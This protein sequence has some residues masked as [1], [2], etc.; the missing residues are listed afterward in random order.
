MYVPLIP[1]NGHSQERT[2][3]RTP[4]EHGRGWLITV[5]IWLLRT[6][7]CSRSTLAAAPGVGETKPVSPTRANAHGRSAVIKGRVPPECSIP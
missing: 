4:R 7:R 6:R 5:P 3:D 2:A 1:E